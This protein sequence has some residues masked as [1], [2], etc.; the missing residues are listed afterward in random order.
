MGKIIQVRKEPDSRKRENGPTFKVSVHYEGWDKNSWDELMMEYPNNE[1][2]AR[3]F[4]HTK[5]VKGLVPIPAIKKKDI[6]GLGEKHSIKGIKN[7]TDVWPCRVVFSAPNEQQPPPHLKHL[8]DPHDVLADPSKTLFVEPYMANLLPQSVQDLMV[9]GGLH[10]APSKPRPWKDFDTNDP[11]LSTENECVLRNIPANEKLTGRPYCFPS[12]FEEAYRAAQ[13]DWIKGMLLPNVLSEGTLLKEEYLRRGPIDGVRHSGAFPTETKSSQEAILPQPATRSTSKQATRST[14]KQPFVPAPTLP[15]PIEIT[16]TAYPNQ[17]V[18]RLPASNRWASTLRVAG[19][20]LFIGTYASQS[21]ALYAA[22]CASAQSR[23]EGSQGFAASTDSNKRPHVPNFEKD[24]PLGSTAGKVADLFNTSIE[25]IV[26]AFEERQSNQRQSP[27]PPFRAR[28][29]VAQH[30]RYV[31]TI[32]LSGRYTNNYFSVNVK[33]D[34][35]SSDKRRKKSIPN[36]LH[37]AG[38]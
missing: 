25:S 5:K 1:R 11:P 32:P 19:N 2:L 9:D 30:S 16:D 27:Q 38:K 33:V 28:D 34:G 22:K 24:S 20:D 35:A 14:S 31:H 10:V 6:R 3:I 13:T 12:G 4:T 21:E 37:I 36:R 26:S 15:A 29:W 7:W 17:G 18:R 8:D 23:N